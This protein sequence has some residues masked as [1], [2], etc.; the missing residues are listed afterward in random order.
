VINNPRGDSSIDFSNPLAVKT[1]NRAILKSFYDISNW[2]IPEGYLC[3]PIPGRADYIHYA[4]DLLALSSEGKIPT[5]SN[6]RVLDVGV[7]ANCVYPIIG[8]HEY[9]W[10]FIG[11]DIDK[12]ALA[13]AKAIVESNPSLRGAVELRLQSSPEKVFEGVL[14]RDEKIDLSICNPPF[15]ASAREAQEN[16]QRKSRNLGTAQVRN[17]GGQA[18]ELWS[19]GGEVEFIRRMIQESS[20]ISSQCLWFSTL[21]SKVDNLK[22][23]Y[24]ELRRV[25]VTEYREQMMSQGQKVSRIVAWTFQA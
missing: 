1:L 14:K 10:S 3:P 9:G 22:A 25:R 20:R 23:I 21:V 15:Y 17:F 12:G 5:G 13:S 2:D 11:S 19:P 7:G 8:H 18:A 6:I 24:Q 4:A 16:S